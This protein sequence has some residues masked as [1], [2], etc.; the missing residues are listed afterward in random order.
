M[1]MTGQELAKR[2]RRPAQEPSRKVPLAEVARRMRAEVAA[3]GSIL[4]ALPRGLEVELAHDG[5][6]WELRMRRLMMAPGETEVAICRQAF[7]APEEAEAEYWER[8]Q[9][10]PKTQQ[11]ARYR[12]LTLRWR[13]VG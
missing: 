13:E 10:T 6:Q 8:K 7:G 11:L 1:G 5:P 4:Y 12:G 9:V 3:G 2:L